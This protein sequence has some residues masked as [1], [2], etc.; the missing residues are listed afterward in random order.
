MTAPFQLSD[1]SM[2]TRLCPF[3]DKHGIPKAMNHKING[4]NPAFILCP[5]SL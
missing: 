4:W 1:Y 3:L 5:I 2:T